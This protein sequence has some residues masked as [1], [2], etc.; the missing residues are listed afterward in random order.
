MTDTQTHEGGAHTVA[1]IGIG[2]MGKAMATTLSRA[3]LRTIVW[4]RNPSVS[5]PLADVGASVAAT[6]PDAVAAA[7]VVITMVPD[8]TATT[9]V[10]IEQGM[11]AAM[12]AGSIWAQMGTIGW[13]ATDRLA[14]LTAERRPDVMFVDAPVSGSTG[15]A[16]RGE[17]LVLASG[18]PDAASRL[19]PVFGALGTRTVWLGDAGRGTRMKLVLNTWLA[20]L[21]EGVAETVTL[22]DALGVTT[23]EVVGALTGGPLAAPAAI[24]KLGKIQSDDYTAEFALGMAL[25]DVDLALA[26]SVRRLPVL[27]ALSEQWRHAVDVG[28]GG[29]D[30][31]AAA[32]ALDTHAMAVGL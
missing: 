4:D 14:A 13:V 25:K 5:A 28:L 30:V 29:L 26:S 12:P 18:P 11:L 6:L 7:D 23:D 9:F 20:F 24:A 22:A 1:V 3:G 21:M 10:A 31:S 2:K 17:L 19:E 15:P 27:A 16:E 8:S 32:L